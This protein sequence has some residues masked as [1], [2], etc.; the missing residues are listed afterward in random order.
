MCH[1][2]GLINNNSPISISS[3]HELDFLSESYSFDYQD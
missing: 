1:K 2:N 3:T